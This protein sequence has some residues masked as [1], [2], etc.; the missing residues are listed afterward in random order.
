M[1]K[2]VMIINKLTIVGLGPG[3]FDYLTHKALDILKSSKT[4]YIR[5][6]KHPIVAH[7]ENVGILFESYDYMYDAGDTF[8]EVY[9]NICVD[10]SKKAS[11]NDVVYA[12][13]GSPF[14]AEKTVETLIEME[15]G[16]DW[17]LD[18]IYGV[19]FI[20]AMLTALRRDPVNGL[21]I[22]NALD[23]EA[24]IPDANV[25]NIVIQMYNRMVASRV[26]VHLSNY[27]PDDQL[28]KVVRAA[29][30][31]GEEQIR[32]VYLYEI[33]A[34][35]GLYDHLTSLFVPRVN[36]DDK[37]KYSFDDL[38]H[39]MHKLRSEDGCP[40]DRKQ[41]HH[42]L[43]QYLI[44]EA[45]EVLN[46]IDHEDF[47]ELEEELGDVLLQIV[48]HSRIAEQSGYFGIHDVTT[49]ICDKMIRRHPHV[50]GDTKVDDAQEVLK[51]WEQ[52]KKEEKQ[53]HLHVEAMERIPV[54]MPA[55]MRAYKIQQKAA[56]VGFDW[57]TIE[58]AF[59][60]FKEEIDEF[61][62]EYNNND[63][64]LME[65]EM[66]DLL[67]SVV[68]I[69]RFLEIQPE[70]AIGKTNDKFLK[71]FRYVEE[72]ITQKGDKIQEKSLDELDRLW[73]NAKKHDFI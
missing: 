5:T 36:F 64:A 32:E 31:D 25:D 46:A 43:K 33:D 62:Q 18:I 53:E 67:F 41:T 58:G 34:E 35:D 52:I 26:K 42:T 6:L 9:E 11:Q 56:D 27:Y 40:W 73:E 57:D 2:R 71:R 13:P 14:V 23:M 65:K 8:D 19:S 22:L 21:K 72:Q 60:K 51:N 39:I 38:V 28:V 1:K 54:S 48:F 30:V 4:V 10:I 69:C 29:G 49:G 15:G 59:D 47:Y 24:H 37:K 61:I 50:F 12:V 66:G 16:S 68:N 44:E 20:D 7:L 17:E 55:L 70:I 45:Y 63:K 3:G